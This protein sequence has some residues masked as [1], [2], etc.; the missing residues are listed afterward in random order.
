MTGIV[1]MKC[2]KA[3]GKGDILKNGKMTGIVVMKRVKAIG[4]GDI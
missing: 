2:V 1:V 3:I 4:K